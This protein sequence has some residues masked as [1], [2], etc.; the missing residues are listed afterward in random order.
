M[1]LRFKQIQCVPV[2]NTS[3]TQCNVYM[4]GLTE[5]GELWFKRDT[6]SKWT[7]EPV[8]FVAPKK[9]RFKD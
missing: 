1:E 5:S 7:K 3:Q 8:E 4:Y 9:D 2:P 6:D